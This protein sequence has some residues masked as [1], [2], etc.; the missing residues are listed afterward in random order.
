MGTYSQHAAE[1]LALVLQFQKSTIWNTSVTLTPGMEDLVEAEARERATCAREVPL[2]FEQRK[3]LF[4][5]LLE[6]MDGIL[7]GRDGAEDRWKN[8][9]E[10][11]EQNRQNVLGKLLSGFS[12]PSEAFK[13]LQGRIYEEERAFIEGLRGLEAPRR[14]GELAKLA[15]QLDE[16]SVLL[17]NNYKDLLDKLKSIGEL[18]QAQVTELLVLLADTSKLH[19]KRDAD[20]GGDIYS[21]AS[22]LSRVAAEARI[23][24]ELAPKRELEDKVWR[25]IDAALSSLELTVRECGW[26]VGEAE[27]NMSLLRAAQ[28]S[29]TGNIHPIFRNLRR[30]TAA[31]VSPSPSERAERLTKECESAIADQA[32][33]SS[34]TKGASDDLKELGGELLKK[35]DEVVSRIDSV[36]G[37]FEDENRGRFF[38]DVSGATREEMLAKQKWAERWDRIDR[39]KL[40]ATYTTQ[41]ERA[42]RFFDVDLLRAY[43]ELLRALAPRSQKLVPRDPSD[44]VTT[45]SSDPSASSALGNKYVPDP[46]GQALLRVIGEHRDNLRPRIERCRESL[47]NALERVLT[48]LGK[49]E[50]R[51]LYLRGAVETSLVSS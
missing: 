3:P 31:F 38:E 8:A 46:E 41:R 17:R 36:Y 2:Y 45:A 13:N 7:A 27:K 26:L 29:E 32:G 51:N 40:S 5:T 18:Q 4:A 20:A 11:M 49:E 19:G 6:A 43:E 9:L 16:F 10:A 22:N 12:K 42:T 47:G 48:L 50:L 14:F 28:S 39:L 24:D 34:L 37:K 1:A 15:K 33:K 23:G 30:Q 25:S 44:P 21:A 35:A